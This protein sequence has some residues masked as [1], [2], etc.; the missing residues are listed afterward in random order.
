M[1]SQRRADAPRETQFVGLLLPPRLCREVPSR[2]GGATDGAARS[3]DHTTTP[4][5]I[6]RPPARRALTEPREA[7]SEGEPSNPIHRPNGEPR[8]AEQLR[9]HM[10]RTLEDGYRRDPCVTRPTAEVSTLAAP[11]VAAGD[12]PDHIPSPPPIPDPPHA[13]TNPFNQL[14]DHMNRTHGEFQLQLGQLQQNL[15]E[16]RGQYETTVTTI[17]G[18]G[19]QM[20]ASAAAQTQAITQLLT[21]RAIPYEAARVITPPPWNDRETMQVQGCFAKW[22]GLLPERRPTPPRR[23]PQI[24]DSPGGSQGRRQ[25][26]HS[27]SSRR[28]RSESP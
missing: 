12:S 27:P 13:W 23:S 1:V 3:A 5:S 8:S 14:S 19:D 7:A 26:S 2:T 16:V 20:K 22:T 17:R 18:L 4:G 25:P 21:A 6:L 9:G 15:R 10:G 11:T 28:D 24:A